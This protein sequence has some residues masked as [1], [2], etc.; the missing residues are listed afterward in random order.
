MSSAQPQC[1][2]GLTAFHIRRSLNSANYQIHDGYWI[3]KSII[4]RTATT[5]YVP[6][7]TLNPEHSTNTVFGT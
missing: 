1:E 3:A 5:A 7:A 4:G 6:F 2:G